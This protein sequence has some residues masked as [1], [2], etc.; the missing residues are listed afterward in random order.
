MND[1]ASVLIRS[2]AWCFDLLL[3]GVPLVVMSITLFNVSIGTMIFSFLLFSFYT[4]FTPVMAS[5]VTLGKK[6]MSIHIVQRNTR[7][8]VNFR[9]MLIRTLMLNI[10]C[11]LTGG[12]VLLV[13]IVLMLFTKGTYSLHDVVAQTTVT[14]KEK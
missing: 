9:Q 6:L 1:V 11:M 5:G 14:L 3:I 4:C 8:Q 13:S 7:S 2:I 10:C 12:I